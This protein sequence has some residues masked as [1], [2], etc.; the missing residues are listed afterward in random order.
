[1]SNDTRVVFPPFFICS[2]SLTGQHI[3]LQ[4]DFIDLKKTL[5]Q[6]KIE[7]KSLHLQVLILD[8]NENDN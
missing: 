1:M 5:L 6:S 4:T 2:L 7:P 3:I 8:R